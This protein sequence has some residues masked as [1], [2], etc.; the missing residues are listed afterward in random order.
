MPGRLEVTVLDTNNGDALK[1]P[2][3][4]P[5]NAAIPLPP[6]VRPTL[7]ET[8]SSPFTAAARLP[9]NDG[10][11]VGDLEGDRPRPPR[12]AAEEASEEKLQPKTAAGAPSGPVLAPAPP[13]RSGAFQLD[14]STGAVSTIPNQPAGRRGRRLP[15]MGPPRPGAHARRPRRSGCPPEEV[16]A[17]PAR[18]PG[19]DG[20][21][22]YS[23]DR[24]DILV[25]ARA[26]SRRPTPCSSSSST[27]VRHEAA[28]RPV[29]QPSRA[30]M[31]FF[32][33]RRQRR[34]P[35]RRPPLFAPR[36]RRAEAPGPLARSRP[37]DP[38][39]K[40]GRSGAACH[41]RR[42]PR[43]LPRPD[44]AAGVPSGGRGEEGT[45]TKSALR[46][47]ASPPPPR[48]AATPE[49]PRAPLALTVPLDSVSCTARKGRHPVVR[50]VEEATAPMLAPHK[51]ASS[52]LALIGW[53]CGHHRAADEPR[54]TSAGWVRTP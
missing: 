17:D 42:P 3:G 10:Q 2:D 25:R 48:L 14:V 9:G 46:R 24:Q 7:A 37:S 34:L 22:F 47:G 40:G 54:T 5:L 29:H 32:V 26:Q 28:G 30:V 49:R 27:T 1:K 8:P 44:P 33:S 16:A 21:Q 51:S 20:P 6:G 19:F 43:E 12:P 41:P 53:S 18:I 15:A 38:T 36:R 39:G 31:P 4:N 13:A 50:E 23:A 45:G 11:A 52:R 35:G